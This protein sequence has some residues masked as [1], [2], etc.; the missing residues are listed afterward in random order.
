[1]SIGNE[2]LPETSVSVPAITKQ[3]ARPVPPTPRQAT[4]PTKPHSKKVPSWLGAL[5]LSAVLVLVLYKLFATSEHVVT[6]LVWYTVQPDTMQITVTERGNLESQENIK[7]HC[8]VDDVR[9]DQIDG[10]PILWV[11]PNGTSVEA[12]DP[13]IEFDDTSHR[14]QLDSRVLATERAQAEFLQADAKYKNQK[15]QNETDRAD[16]ELAVRLAELELEMYQD[17]AK[18]THRLEVEEIQRTIDDL[19]NE[20]L[21]AQTS[22]QLKQHERQGIEILFKMGYSGKSE[23]DRSRLEVLQAQSEHAAKLNR[24]TTYRATL[25]KKESY[26]FQMQILQLQ[27]AVATAK[28]NQR[29]VELNNEAALAQAEAELNAAERSLAK[30]REILDRHHENIALCKVVAERE[31]MVVYAKSSR[32][33][34]EVAAGG[35]AY[36][37]QHVLSLPNLKKMQVQTAIHESVLDQVEK[38]LPATISIDAFPE[39][40]YPGTVTSVAVM[41]DTSGNVS[42]DT[43]VYQTIVTIDEEV[44]QLKPGM[45]AVVDIHVDELA[46]VLAVPVQAIVQREKETW[47][48]VESGREAKRRTVRLGKTNDKFV[49]IVD[50][51]EPGERVVLNP[52]SLIDES[53][54]SPKAK[55]PSTQ[56]TEGGSSAEQL[57][58][59]TRLFDRASREFGTR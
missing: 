28:R 6:N 36:K 47:C 21:A 9:G 20:I 38:G 10:T 26:E 46:N 58:V 51:V 25:E 12:G 50:G 27:G 53:P 33:Y 41:P 48:F 13:L 19:Q 34:R 40:R 7:I 11:T 57:A 23:L 14:E 42:S 44:S 56:P 8:Q 55:E 54:T 4:E 37:R 39:M 45:T 59:A 24:L 22:M 1:M 2:V 18:G 52:M 32:S 31:G 49:Q 5:A 3:M 15:T 35:I 29:Q 17:K 30:E 16:A 43:K